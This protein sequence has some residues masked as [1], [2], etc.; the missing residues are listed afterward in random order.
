L[1]NDAAPSSDL[2]RLIAFLRFVYKSNRPESYYFFLKNS[3]LNIPASGPIEIYVKFAKPGLKV[4]LE[5]MLFEWTGSKSNVIIFY[6]SDH[7]TSYET[8]V[9][10]FKLSPEW[11][12]LRSTFPGV[13][14]I[15][16]VPEVGGT[17]N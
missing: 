15:D 11:L 16:F 7:A 13:E 3:Y 5:S 4:E 12:M 8:I 6:D 2:E 14:V 1:L 9:K 17:S 10:N